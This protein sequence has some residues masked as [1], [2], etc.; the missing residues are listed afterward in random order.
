MGRLLDIH[1][2][3]LKTAATKTA[4][5]ALQTERVVILEK[6]AAVAQSLLQEKYPNNFTEADV[7]ALTD[8]L[9]QRD[10]EIEEAQE[11]IAELDEA[12]RIM[13]RAFVDEQQKLSQGA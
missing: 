2:Q 12:G 7:V 8:G 10:I 5:E 13:A 3:L 6:Y 4:E 1:N 9:I 11:K